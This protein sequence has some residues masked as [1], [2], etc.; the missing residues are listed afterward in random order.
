HFWFWRNSWN[1][2]RSAFDRAIALD[3][4]FAPAY[5]HPVEIA[6]NDNEPGA[7]LRYVQGYLAISSGTPEAAGMRLLGELVDPGHTQPG[8][9][10]R[11]IETAS[12]P[13]LYHLAL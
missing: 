12:P 5:V 1:D 11:E 4:E 6:L 8:D 3:S 13:A 2:A 7:A 9:F 10:D